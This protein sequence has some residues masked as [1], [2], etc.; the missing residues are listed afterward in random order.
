MATKADL[1]ALKADFYLAQNNI[2]RWLVTAVLLGQLI[3]TLPGLLRSFGLI[4]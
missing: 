2:I 1:L 4:E 3:P